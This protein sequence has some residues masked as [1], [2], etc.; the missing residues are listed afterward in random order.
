V[1]TYSFP[2]TDLRLLTL[3]QVAPVTA[4]NSTDVSIYMPNDIFYDW[5]THEKIEGKGSVIHKDVPYTS[6]PIYYRGTSMDQKIPMSKT[7]AYA[8]ILR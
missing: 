7:F 1:A 3:H 4:D 6:I 8:S 2:F 5:Y